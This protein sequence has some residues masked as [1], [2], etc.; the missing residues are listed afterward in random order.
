MVQGQFTKQDAPDEQEG[1]KCPEC[2]SNNVRFNAV[3]VPLLEGDFL[4]T[5]GSCNNQF[6]G[7]EQDASKTVTA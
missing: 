3:H 5:C 4:Y 6:N 1:L 7:E 2:G